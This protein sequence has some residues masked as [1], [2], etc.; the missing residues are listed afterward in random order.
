[1]VDKKKSSKVMKKLSK[2]KYKERLNPVMLI[3][4]LQNRN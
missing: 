3:L 4:E 2:G 1:M